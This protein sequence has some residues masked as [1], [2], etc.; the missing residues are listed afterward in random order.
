MSPHSDAARVL[1]GWRAPDAAQEQLRAEF[2]G[3]LAANPDGT[4]RAC[5]EGH[6]TASALVVQPSTGRVLLTRHATVGRWLQLGGHCEPGDR[7]LAA[8]ATR[9]G[10]EESGLPD[11]EVGDAPLRL[12]RHVVRC[13]WSGGVDE[14]H[15]L[16][17]Q[18]LALAGP[19]AE[20]QPEGDAPLRWFG[21][22][23]LP[24]D[25]D[26]AVRALVAAARA[27]LVVE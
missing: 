24:D 21:W 6:L 23:D 9:E 18:Y 4:D 7:D 27:S 8:A 20:P 3:F 19:D 26:G 1:A 22:D 25:A 11:L 15:H 14:L 16:D 12:D 17:V 2:A 10:R 13:R 5:R